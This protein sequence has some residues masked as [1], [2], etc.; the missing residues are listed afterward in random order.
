MMSLRKTALCIAASFGAMTGAA[1]AAEYEFTVPLSLAAMPREINEALVRCEIMAPR[2]GSTSTEVIGAG[3]SRVAIAGGA[4]SGDVRV[5]VNRS[6][7]SGS[8]TPTRWGC[9]LRVF[10]VV[11]GARSEFWSYDDPTT[12]AYG[13][14]SPPG[15]TPRLEI[16]AAAGAVKTVAVS[17]TF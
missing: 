11:G 14:K 5:G 1:S 7:L 2:A 8:R 13:L 9:F 10:G 6:A 4:Y 16:P 3:E 12:G 17:G 15:T